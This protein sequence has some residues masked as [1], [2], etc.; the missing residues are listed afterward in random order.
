M[1]QEEA[2][3]EAEDVMMTDSATTAVTGT[4]TETETGPQATN[5]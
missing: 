4:A 5:D 2:T 3:G 1:E